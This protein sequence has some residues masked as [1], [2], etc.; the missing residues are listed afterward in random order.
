MDLMKLKILRKSKDTIIRTKRQP[1]DW[2]KS[3][4]KPTSDRGLIT[5][6]YKELKKVDTNNPKNP[7]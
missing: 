7:I 4:T 5:K 3:F 2:K 6:I 1:I